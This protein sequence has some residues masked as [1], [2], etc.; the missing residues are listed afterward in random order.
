[1]CTYDDNFDNIFDRAQIKNIKKNFIFT[2]RV[3]KQYKNKKLSFFI[4]KSNFLNK[5]KNFIIDSKLVYYNHQIIRQN[6]LK[7]LKEKLIKHPVSVVETKQFNNGYLFLSESID[8]CKKKLL[9]K[10]L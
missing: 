5:Y 3:R 8:K 4:K 7:K 9:S 10:N 6:Q 1:M 2:G